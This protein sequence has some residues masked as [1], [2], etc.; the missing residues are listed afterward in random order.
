MLGG[1]TAGAVIYKFSQD[2]PS[3]DAVKNYT[4]NVVTT[5]FSDDDKVIAEFSSQKRKTLTPEE[6]PQNLINAFVAAEDNEFFTHKGI[7]PLSIMRAAFKVMMAGGHAVQGGST[8]TQQVA[9]QILL[10]NIKSYS[11]KIREALLAIRIEKEFSKKEIITLYLNHIFL[12]MHAYGVEAA[13]YTYFGKAAKDLSVPEAAVIAGLNDA[14]S[15]NNP[16]TNPKGARARQRYVLGRMLATG[17]ISAADYASY[18]KEPLKI[19]NRQ[20]WDTYQ[21]PYFT[22]YVRRYI[23][24]KYG[25]DMLYGGGLKIYT[26]LNLKN[27]IAAQDA[28]KSGLIALDKRIGMRAPT[29][30]FSSEKERSEFLKKEH[31][32]LIEAAHAYKMLSEEGELSTPLKIEEPTPCEK[33]KNYD[34]VIIGKGSAKDKSLKVQMGN[35]IGVIRADD[36]KWVLDEN[37]EEIYKDKTIRNPYTQLKVGDVITIQLKE[38]KTNGVDEYILEQEP[39]VQGALLSYRVSDGALIAMVGGYDYYVTRSEFNRATQAKRQPGSTFKPIVYAAALDSGLTPSTIVVDSPIVYKD[40]NEKTQMEK[41]WKPENST[42]HFY[43]DTTL[44]NALAFSRN[45]PTIK[46]L[47]HI[48]VP[49]VVQYAHKLGIKSPLNEDLSLALGSSGITLEELTKAFGVFANKGQRLNSYFIKKVIDRNGAALEEYKA[50]EPETVISDSTAFLVTSMLKSV[51]DYGTGTPVKALERP[52]A[53]KTGTTQDSKDALFV[54]FVPQVLTGV[55]TGFDEQIPLGRNEAGARAAAPIWL[56]YM[57]VATAELEKKE[58]EAPPSV[59]QVQIDAETGD[60]PGP[61]ST[62]RAWEYFANGTAPGQMPGAVGPD[63][64]FVATGTEANRTKVVTGNSDV[65][66][67]SRRNDDTESSPD[68]IM[69]DDL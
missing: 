37:P 60:V 15:N 47:Q 57:Q 17:M 67:N 2:L 53:G 61:N 49:T 8:I 30:T 36:Y 27:Q 38:A 26:T 66:P 56:Q 68:Q 12:G 48:K 33:G 5:V 59:V 18:V 40:T 3:L 34:S 19:M 50:P 21:A 14:P 32:E 20:D 45:I 11:R 4:P 25:D 63:G 16:L 39:M 46:I 41:V 69:R 65:L 55:W 13:A 6:M 62:K 52:V 51:V 22:E 28:I 23:K 43:G 29:K 64:Q 35:R 24:N 58:F 31:K 42:D 10:S 9:K 1:L 7:N 54:G 44:R